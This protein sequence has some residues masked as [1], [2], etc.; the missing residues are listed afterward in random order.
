V[1]QIETGRGGVVLRLASL[2]AS[3]VL[4]ASDPCLAQWTIAAFAGGVHTLPADLRITHTIDGLDLTFPDTAYRSESLD[5]PIYYGYRVGRSVWRGRLLV[6]GELIH[7]KVFATFDD[8]SAGFGRMGGA[9]VSGV[10]ATA[11]VQHFAMSHG[12]NLILVN[13]AWRQPI[14]RTRL[15]AVARAGIGPVLAHGE[16]EIAGK[17]REDY[18]WAGT[19]VQ[20]AGG[21]ELRVWHGLHGIVEYKFTRARPRIDTAGGDAVL[22]TRS[23]H[24]AIGASW[25][26]GT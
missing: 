3:L 2:A 1:P 16:T 12:L 9:P 7:A 11:V 24:V 4:T 22:A 6:E 20:A 13:A 17:R 21:F 25:M 10:P 19:A 26:F 18:Q 15:A 23:H 8:R 14:A 5:A